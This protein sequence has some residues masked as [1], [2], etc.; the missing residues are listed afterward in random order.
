MNCCAAGAE[1]TIEPITVAMRINPS[2][3]FWYDYTYGFAHFFMKDFDTA[4]ENIEKSIDRNPNVIFMRT[5]FAASL[6]MAGRQDDA[7]WQ[8]VELS[9]LGFN[10]TL[11]EYIGESPVQDPAYR[12]LYREGLAKAGLL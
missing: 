4:V 6:A 9:G 2:F 5:A 11:E 1:K 10:K 8:I 12:A 7:E 3:P